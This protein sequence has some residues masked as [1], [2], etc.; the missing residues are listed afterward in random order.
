[1]W[2]RSRLE[3][4]V[5]NGGSVQYL[6]FWGHTPKAAGAVDASCLSQWFPRPFVEDGVRYAT[7]EHYMMAAKARLFHDEPPTPTRASPRDGAAPI[8]SGSR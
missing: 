6:L 4:H 8:C 3:E 5:S 7:A 1:M 2:N